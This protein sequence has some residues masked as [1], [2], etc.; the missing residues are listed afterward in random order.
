MQAFARRH[1]VRD[2][3]LFLTGG[4]DALDAIRG[5]FFAHRPGHS[6]HASAP[7]AHDPAGGDLY[8]CS[9]GLLRYGNDAIGLWGSVASLADPALIVQRLSWVEAR[10]PRAAGTPLQ[11]GGPRPFHWLPNP[12]SRQRR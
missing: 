10:P 6:A 8:D 3:W 1:G 5:A 4:E 7:P 2:G 11:R 9:M 12:P